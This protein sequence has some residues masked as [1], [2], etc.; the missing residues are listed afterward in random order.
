MG[1]ALTG[2]ECKQCKKV[3]TAR[4]V[5]GSD[6]LLFE[7]YCRRCAHA[8]VDFDTFIARALEFDPLAEVKNKIA[9]QERLEQEHAYARLAAYELDI[10]AEKASKNSD[11]RIFVPDAEFARYVSFLLTTPEGRNTRCWCR[12]YFTYKG[13][14][15]VS[16]SA[17]D[18]LGP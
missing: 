15:V 9:E 8:N 2:A 12:T 5:P 10:L 3:F 6:H 14:V 11:N 1:I 18:L 13:I 7:E 17:N 4:P 16:N